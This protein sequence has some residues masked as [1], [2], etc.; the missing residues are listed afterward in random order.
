MLDMFKPGDRVRV[1]LDGQVQRGIWVF[2][3][4]YPDDQTVEL[5]PIKMASGRLWKAERVEVI[6]WDA[7]WR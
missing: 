4:F 3:R 6:D 7:K 1:K 2:V 5:R